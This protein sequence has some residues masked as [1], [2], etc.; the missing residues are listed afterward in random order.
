[1]ALAKISELET[2]LLTAVRTVPAFSANG[3]SVFSVDDLGATASAQTLP[4]VGVSY[5]GAEPLSEATPKTSVHAAAL[6]TVQFVIVV[7][8]QYRY[9]GQDDTKQQ[10]FDLLD[11]VRSVVLGL[12][13]SNTRPWRF[14][15][16][17]PETEVSGDGV[18]FYSQV[19]QTTLPIVGNFNFS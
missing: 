6:I 3:F 14:V 9:T 2:E 17:R 11:Q 19:W 15:G 7:A 12:K 1:M 5:D 13:G 10:A 8:V 16:E 4:C 18:V